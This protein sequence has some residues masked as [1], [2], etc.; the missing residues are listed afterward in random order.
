MAARGGVWGGCG[1]IIRGF[2]GTFD[3]MNLSIIINI[4]TLS[5][6]AKAC[7]VLHTTFVML[8][9]LSFSFKYISLHKGLSS[10]QD[11]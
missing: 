6:N 9:I 8:S 5:F 10:I 1:Q 11:L 7:F 2:F 3:H 4:R